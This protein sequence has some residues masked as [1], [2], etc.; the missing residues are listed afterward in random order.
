MDRSRRYV[1]QEHENC[2]RRTATALLPGLLQYVFNSVVRLHSANI[3]QTMGH[4][5]HVS[6][7][8]HAT[9][10]KPLDGLTRFTL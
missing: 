5:L 7:M 4:L 2:E 9:H 3:V 6:S 8:Y 1:S 10:I